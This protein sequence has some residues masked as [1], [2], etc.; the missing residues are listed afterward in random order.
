MRCLKHGIVAESGRVRVALR[1]IP[2]MFIEF[3]NGFAAFLAAVP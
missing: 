2:T 1:H 3:G